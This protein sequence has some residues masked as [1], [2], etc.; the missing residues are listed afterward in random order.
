MPDR[1]PIDI[2]PFIG[3]AEAIVAS[4]VL[5]GAGAYRRWNRSDAHP[6]RDLGVN[7]YGCAAPMKT[8]SAA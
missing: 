5:A 2:S 4:H 7:P 8:S 3:A 1:V 6:E